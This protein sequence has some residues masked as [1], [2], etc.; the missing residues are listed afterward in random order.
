MKRK[1][2]VTI[3]NDSGEIIFYNQSVVEEKDSKRIHVPLKEIHEL[4]KNGINHDKL[5]VH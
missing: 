5:P 1:V 2:E 3:R 4:H